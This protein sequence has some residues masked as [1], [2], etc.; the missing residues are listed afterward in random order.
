MI[1]GNG[2]QDAFS[3]DTA[4]SKSAS[5]HT[6]PTVSLSL[7]HT[8]IRICTSCTNVTIHPAAIRITSVL[9]QPVKT[10]VNVMRKVGLQIAAVR[11]PALPNSLNHK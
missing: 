3:K 2:K 5:N 6:Q 1:A 11:K 4:A 9:A 10:F 7:L 8:V